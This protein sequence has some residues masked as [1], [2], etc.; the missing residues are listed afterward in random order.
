MPDTAFRRGLPPTHS[1]D[2]DW[3][4]LC[5]TYSVVIGIEDSRND[6]PEYPAS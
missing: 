1:P 4:F 3:E 2:E 6:I 5:I